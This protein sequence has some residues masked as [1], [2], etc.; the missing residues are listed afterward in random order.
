MSH[1]LHDSSPEKDLDLSP[2]RGFLC[3]IFE[4]HV[5]LL[6]ITIDKA[7]GWI[8]TKLNH[9]YNMLAWNFVDYTVMA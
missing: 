1:L 5:T 7:V 4:Q 9:V 6:A 8:L 3:Q 2:I